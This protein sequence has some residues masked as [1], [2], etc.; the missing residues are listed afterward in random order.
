MSGP[1]R[2]RIVQMPKWGL[3]MQ[4]GTVR[5]WHVAIGEVV[6]AGAPLCDIETAKITNEFEAPEA[7][8]VARLLAAPGDVVAVGRPIAVLAEPG[9]EAAA[10]EAALAAETVGTGSTAREEREI[11]RR[12]PTAAGEIACLDAGEAGRSEA[13]VLL[14]GWGGDH[15]S[16]TLVQPAL[17]AHS[18]AVAFDLPGHGQST[19]DVGDGSAEALAFRLD[20]AMRALG[21]ERVHL[22]AHSYGAELAGALVRR[23]GREVGA[24]ALLAPVGLGGSVNAGYIASFL[25]AR[26]KR[27]MRPVLEQLFASPEL[28]GREMVSEALHLLRDE[29]ASAALRRIADHIAAS[30][31]PA[32]PI[33][34]W[35]DGLRLLVLWGAQDAIVPMPPGLAERLGRRLHVFDGCGHLPHVEAA[36]RSVALLLDHLAS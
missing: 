31:A 28:V 20:E 26:R 18:R 23:G 33:P 13:V 34:V 4:E 7:G 35:A 24:V 25:A 16:W 17:A 3:A 9:T 12:V 19:R 36:G 10:I 8:I 14:H 22:V 2:V 1:P 15:R 6:A 30:A 29:A 5:E 27:D 11:V 32:A 21:L